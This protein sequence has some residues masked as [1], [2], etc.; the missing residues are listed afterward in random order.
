MAEDNNEDL[1]RW[2]RNTRL[3]EASKPQEDPGNEGAWEYALPS[4]PD[5]LSDSRLSQEMLRLASWRG[6]AKRLLGKVNAELVELEADFKT[7]VHQ[8]SISHR[9][10]MGRV[11]LEVIE[12]ITLADDAELQVMRKRITRLHVL[13]IHLETREST[14]ADYWAAL[15]RE[16]SRREMTRRI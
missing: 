13:R 12:A 8:R 3:P 7:L 15:S 9:K 4:D 6:Y 11:A 10:E 14:Y 1:Q 5:A 2:L 16:Q